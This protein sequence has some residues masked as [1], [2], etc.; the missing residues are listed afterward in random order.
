MATPTHTLRPLACWKSILR[1]TR[2]HKVAT[3][4][5]TTYHQNVSYS[6]YQIPPPGQAPQGMPIPKSPN[7]HLKYTILTSIQLPKRSK[8]SQRLPSPLPIPKNPS[9]LSAPTKSPSWTPRALEQPYSPKPTRKPQKWATS[10][11]CV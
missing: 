2:Q 7:M 3:R 10:C 8:S 11:S 4:S 9:K 5:L 6:K 1:R